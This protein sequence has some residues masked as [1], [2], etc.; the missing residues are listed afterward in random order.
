MI[1][2]YNVGA[3]FRTLISNVRCQSDFLPRKIIKLNKL[4]E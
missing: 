4:E 3:G 1:D 2:S